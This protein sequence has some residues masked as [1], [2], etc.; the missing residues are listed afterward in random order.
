MKKEKVKLNAIAPVDNQSIAK[1]LHGFRENLEQELKSF[2]RLLRQ[3]ESAGGKYTYNNSTARRNNFLIP[4]MSDIIE[5]FRH[6][7]RTATA[8][9]YSAAMNSFLRFRNGNDI[10]LASIDSALIEDYQT[11]LRSTGLTL[12]SIS[13]YMRIMRAVYNNAVRHHLTSDRSPFRTVFTGMEKTRKR[14]IQSCDIKRIRNLNLS[15]Q[16]RLEL[17]RDIFIF[18]FLCRGMSFIDA[19][20]LRKTDIK[21]GIITYRRHKTGQLLHI[22]VITQIRDLL[23]KHSLRD[24]PFLLPIINNPGQNERRQYETALRRINKSLKIIGDMAG[25]PVSLTT[26]VGRHSWA[27]IA[28][29]KNIPVNV[30]SDALGHDSVATTQIYLDAIDTAIIDRANEM[31]INEI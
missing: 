11:Y 14:A 31:V 25:I 3:F 24:S 16:P 27:T 2:E 15:M 17:A 30:I 13:F 7:N 8:N 22:K 6:L 18:L 26:Y 12:N 28:K 5:R 23:E 20:F 19:A 29:T 9:N 21:S 4:F 10:P 1:L